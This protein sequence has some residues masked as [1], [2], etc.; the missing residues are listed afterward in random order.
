MTD[1]HPKEEGPRC[2]R[3]R[4]EMVQS[5]L[6]EPG[7]QVGTSAITTGVTVG[8]G[9]KCPL[10]RKDCLIKSLERQLEEAKRC[11][12]ERYAHRSFYRRNHELESLLRASEA[13]ERE[14]Q[15]KLDEAKARGEMFASLDKAWAEGMERQNDS[16]QSERDAAL[17]QVVALREWIET[18][19]QHPAFCGANC[20]KVGSYG[21]DTCTCGKVSILNDTS[22]AAHLRVEAIRRE[23]TA[24]LMQAL[25]DYGRHAAAI[26]ELGV[27]GCDYDPEEG[28]PCTC[29]LAAI[30]GEKGE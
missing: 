27:Q 14:L 1:P 13:R 25:R 2:K 21:A 15:G 12:D 23:A 10:P 17:D 11:E 6:T 22:A 7:P 30:L 28:I 24:E 9:M 3:C 16:L 18:T 26:P 19:A 5:M 8:F 29:G 4:S 20:A